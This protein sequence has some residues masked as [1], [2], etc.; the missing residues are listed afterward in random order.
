MDRQIVVSGV[1]P[2]AW[3]RSRMSMPRAVAARCHH[4]PCL[5]HV[6]RE[7]HAVAAC[8]RRT[9]RHFAF[10]LFLQLF[11]SQVGLRRCAAKGSSTTPIPSMPLGSQAEL[12]CK[13]RSASLKGLIWESYN[14]GGCQ[15]LRAERPVV[16]RK[17]QAAGSVS[18][19]KQFEATSDCG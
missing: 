12:A 18:R 19:R 14:G 16:S 17:Q 5:C 11:L 3:D 8:L 9:G 6:L 1:W 13:V 2:L 10:C 7:E 15:L 4:V